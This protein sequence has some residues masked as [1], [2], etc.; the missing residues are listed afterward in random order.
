MNKLP[1]IKTQFPEWYQEI[2]YQA[3]L[4]DQSPVR[5]CMVIRPYGNAIWEE[6]KAIL[7][8]KIKESGAENAV[9]PLLIPESFLKKEADHVE[10]FA[11]ELAVVTHAGGKKL[12][13]PLVIRPTSETIIHHMFAQ[14]IKSW[15]DLPLKINQWANVV[16]WEKRPRA[17]LRTTEFFWQEGHTAHATKEDAQKTTEQMLEVYRQI[18][19]DY[20]A[21]PVQTGR[22]S[23]GEKFPGAEKTYTFEGFMPDAKA[24]QMGTSHLLSQSFA[25][26]FDMQF[27]N[28][29]GQL[30]YPWLT[31][32]GSTTRLVG[33]LVMTHGDQKGLVI[34]PAVAPIQVIIIPIYKTEEE[35]TLVLNT[36][37]TLKKELETTTR[38]KIDD[39]QQKTPGNKFFH[40]E[41][42]GV[43]IR[44]EIGPRDLKNNE[45]VIAD[46]LGSKATVALDNVVEL[47]PTQLNNLQKTLFDKAKQRTESLI[48]DKDTLEEIKA[49]AETNVIKTGFCG[50][51]ECEGVLKQYTLS[52]RCLLLEQLTHKNCFNCQKPS[53]SDCFI[54]RSY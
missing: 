53:Q 44:I 18:A 48:I 33:A 51:R 1:D 7:D 36:A 17:F 52:I 15:R 29:E 5:G 30:E 47:I 41:L 23:E 24:L 2:I 14:W 11:P 46:R 12:D 38:I 45:V 21:I 25:K 6:I 39:D 22:K 8:Q 40:W 50:S 13:E 37:E 28:K 49:V 27:Q 16:R 4:V 3:E 10:G 19:Q 31:S 20:L 34:P 35:R 42:R 43:P 32:W 9:F 26:A 54:A